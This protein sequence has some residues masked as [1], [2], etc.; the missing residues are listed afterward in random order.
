[1]TAGNTLYNIQPTGLERH[2]LIGLLRLAG[3]KVSRRMLPARPCERKIASATT[4]TVVGRLQNPNYHPSLRTPVRVAS[5]RCLQMGLRRFCSTNDRIGWNPIQ[6]VRVHTLVGE[7]TETHN[8]RLSLAGVG[9][10]LLTHLT[11]YRSTSL[12]L[13]G[14]GDQGIWIPRNLTRVLREMGRTVGERDTLPRRRLLLRILHRSSTDTP[15]GGAETK[16]QD[17]G[18]LCP[19]VVLHLGTLC[20]YLHLQRYHLPPRLDLRSF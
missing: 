8:H 4:S 19:T 14:S 9:I 18:H 10:P 6:G 7:A 1:V 2:K 13:N 12:Y 16:A 11:C 5:H 15:G 20:V 17:G 3:I